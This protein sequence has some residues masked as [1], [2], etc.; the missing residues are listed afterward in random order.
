M[1]KNME[2]QELRQIIQNNM[3][4]SSA[5]IEKKTDEEDGGHSSSS[6]SS[7]E[8]EEMSQIDQEISMLNGT[9]MNALNFSKT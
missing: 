1:T 6:S 9:L 5:V 3:H 7:S 8:V 2:N 4:R